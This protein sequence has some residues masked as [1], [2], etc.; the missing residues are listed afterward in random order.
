MLCNF[1]NS[2]FHELDIT[3]QIWFKECATN[4]FNDIDSES[5]CVLMQN[6]AS[7]TASDSEPNN[8]ID[9]ASSVKELEP[10]PPPWFA[11][12]HIH[13]ERPCQPLWSLKQTDIRKFFSVIK[14]HHLFPIRK[15]DIQ[16][17]FKVTRKARFQGNM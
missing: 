7:T 6:V 14:L 8:G 13:L 3:P 9:T 15:T 17:Y 5:N 12:R 1:Q 2:W 10:A 11:A 4:G 16:C